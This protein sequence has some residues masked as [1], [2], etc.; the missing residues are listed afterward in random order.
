MSFDNAYLII[1]L[2]LFMLLKKTSQFETR[3]SEEDSE[4]AVSLCNKLQT[5]VCNS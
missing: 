5:H 2:C 1:Y 3:L 4:Y